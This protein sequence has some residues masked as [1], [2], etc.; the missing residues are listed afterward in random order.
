MPELLL[1]RAADQFGESYEYL[2]TGERPIRVARRLGVEGAAQAFRRMGLPR[3]VREAM[4]RITSTM[5]ESPETMPWVEAL[6][7][8]LASGSQGSVVGIQENLNAFLA[9]LGHPEIPTDTGKKDG[10]DRAVG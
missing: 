3:D 10:K 2:A 7:T 5:R 6:L 4:E 8:I 9:R 1:R